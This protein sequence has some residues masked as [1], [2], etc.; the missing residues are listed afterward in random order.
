MVKYYLFFNGCVDVE[1][2]DD[3]ASLNSGVFTFDSAFRAFLAMEEE[4]G[5]FSLELQGVRIWEKVRQVVFDLIIQ[6]LG[7]IRTWHKQRRLSFLTAFFFVAKSFLMF[8]KNPFLIGRTTVLCYGGARRNKL[9]DGKWWNIFFDP[10]FEEWSVS[11]VVL[12]DPFDFKHFV[13]TKS[14]HVRYMD[15][16]VVLR[17]LKIAL[18]LSKVSFSPQE[19][20][21]IKEIESHIERVFG[22]RL[23]LREYFKKVLEQRK[24][25]LPLISRLLKRTR[26]KLILLLDSSSRTTFIE[27]ARHLEI[28]VVELQHGVITKYHLGYNF[29]PPRR[30]HSTFPDYLLV[31]GDYWRKVAHYPIPSAHVI[32][33]GY[34]FFEKNLEKYQGV[35]KQ[36]LIVFISQGTIGHLLSKFAAELSQ[37][38]GLGY[39]IVYKLHPGEIGTW[40]ND[41]PW[42]VS[43]GIRVIDDLT[44]SLYDLFSVAKIQ[45]GVYST[46]LFEGLG[47][48]LF[49][50][51]YKAPGIEYLSDL[52]DSGVVRVVSDVKGMLEA[53]QEY[54][55][56]TPKE[57]SKLFFKP[58]S[59]HNTILSLNK[60][61]SEH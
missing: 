35:E 44:V 22:L 30:V 12:E 60:I 25:S 17:N 1:Q 56:R 15:F 8:W 39:K 18:G 9:E 14:K 55:S 29:P 52:I 2:D 54:Q 53:L 32:S 21:I 13:P 37:V 31:F 5:L 48:D 43:S 23:T 57:M 38:K 27:A 33:V 7:L 59:I 40:K 47:F 28:P 34:P 20:A 51:L 16:L 61:L 58:N 24:A 4:L 49:T 46:G 3:V 36:D 26:P 41:Y 6:E 45:V 50:V 10:L 11:H 42:L 19:E